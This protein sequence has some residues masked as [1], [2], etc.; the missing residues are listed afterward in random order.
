MAN[1]TKG[2][3]ERDANQTLQASFNEVDHSLTTSGFLTGKVGHKVTLTIS[4][5]TVLNDTQV[6]NFFDGLVSLYSLRL[7]FTDSS[8]ATLISAERIS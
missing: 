3:S 7:I 2:L 4:T 5:T 8:Y 1:T 6:Y